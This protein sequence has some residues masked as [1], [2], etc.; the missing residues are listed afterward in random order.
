M[1]PVLEPQ[2]IERVRRFGKVRSY[3]AGEALAKVGDMGHGLI[4]ILSGHI[5]H[6]A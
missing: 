2:E 3:G 5:E 6:P 1:F 4:I